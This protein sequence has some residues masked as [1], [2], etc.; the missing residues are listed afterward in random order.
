MKRSQLFVKTRKDAPANEVSKNAQLLIRAGYVYKVMAGVYAYT[1]LGIRVLEKIKQVVREE[2]DAIG[3]QELIMSSLQRKDTWDVSGRWDEKVVDVWFKTNLQDGTELGLAW[4]HEEAIIEM[5]KEHI[6]S[7]KDVPQN[8]YQFQT[9]FR[10]ELRS[11]SGIMRGREFV[12]KDMY[13]CSLDEEQHEKFYQE[14]IDAYMR[15]FHRL[16]IGDDTFVTLAS[17]GAFTQFSHEFQTVCDAGEDYVFH[18]PDSDIYYNR[19]IAPSRAS[20][21][22]SSSEEVKPREDVEGKGMIGVG[23]LAKFFDIPVQQTT[24]TILFE[25]EK[26]GVIAAAIRGDYDVNE[27]KLKVVA[28]VEIL[29]LASEDVVREVTGADIGYAGIID[30]PESVAVYMDDSMAGRKNFEMGANKTDYHSINVNFD[31]DIPTPDEFYDIKEAKE[32]DAHPESGKKYE[33][34]KTAETGNIFNFGVQKSQETDF[35]FTNA[36]GKKQHVYLGSYGIGITRAMG[37]IA[38]NMSDERGLNWHCNIAPYHVYF[39]VFD[40][41]EDEAEALVNALENAG[42]EVLIDDRKVRPG[43]K[44]ADADL[45]GIPLRIVISPRSKEKNSVELKSRVSD[46]SE[47]VGLDEIV[48]RVERIIKG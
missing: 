36:E 38:E 21:F 5:L 29:K 33:V 45:M 19:E 32:G 13:S 2:M 47:L 26:G 11:K 42:V 10:N 18:V 46:E 34:I 14:C 16:G 23:A 30:L 22:D 35:Y 44:F 8:V 6:T 3:G 41:V 27:E 28:G 17:G 20:E 43:D 39:V 31:H 48:E 12:M 9:K 37:V 1:P 15:V 7:Y 4:S 40:G 24:K 25:D